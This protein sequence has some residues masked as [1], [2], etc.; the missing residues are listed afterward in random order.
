MADGHAVRA[1]VEHGVT[2]EHTEAGAEGCHFIVFGRVGHVVDSHA[3]VLLEADVGILGD[4]LEGAIFRRAK[5]EGGCP[6]VAEVLDGR[7]VSHAGEGRNW[8]RRTS[9]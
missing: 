7:S 8:W 6:V 9:E 1:F 5:V 2:G 4:A 3:A